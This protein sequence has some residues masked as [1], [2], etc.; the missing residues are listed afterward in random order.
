M[1]D[2]RSKNVIKEKFVT[3]YET[4]FKVICHWGTRNRIGLL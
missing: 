3:I 4:F 2:K 1:T